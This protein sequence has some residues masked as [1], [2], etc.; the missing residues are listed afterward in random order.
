MV[1]AAIAIPVA[2]TAHNAR[3]GLLAAAIALLAL[4]RWVPGG[5]LVLYPLTLLA[6]WVHEM[7]HGLTALFLG[8][9]FDS[10]EV[11]ADASGLAHTATPEGWR[12]AAVSAGGL[13]APPL[14]GAG[15]LAFAR[16]PTR[17]AAVLLGFAGAL[18]LSAVLWVRSLIGLLTVLPLAAVL[19]VLGWRGGSLRLG[20]AQFLGLIFALDTLSRFDYLFTSTA[21][22][23]GEPV[24]S[25]VSG[26]ANGLF[27]PM[28]LWGIAI[29]AIDLLL[30]GFGLRAAWGG[31][32]ARR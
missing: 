27:P 9:G 12:A 20:I 18:A 25:D 8:G 28:F 10:L 32:G 19:G 4:E 14:V 11:N 30:L 1:A 13:L 7:G 21:T 26:I 23:G 6:T 3:V 16:G 15:V 24:P 31:G 29:G 17:G 5:R 2:S 22:I